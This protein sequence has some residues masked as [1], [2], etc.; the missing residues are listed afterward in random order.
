MREKGID[1]ITLNDD[2]DIYRPDA[3]FPNNWISF[4]RDGTIFLYPM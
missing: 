4:H 3:I 1:I 2:K